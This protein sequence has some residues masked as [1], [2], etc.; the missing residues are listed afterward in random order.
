MVLRW[1]IGY[2]NHVEQS[3]SVFNLTVLIGRSFSCF[4]VYVCVC[5]GK[6]GERRVV[7]WNCR[8]N[9]RFTEKSCMSTRKSCFSNFLK[10]DFILGGKNTEGQTEARVRK[11]D[12]LETKTTQSILPDSESAKQHLWSVNLQCYQYK[13]CMDRWLTQ[14]DPCIE[15]R[16]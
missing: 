10:N 15:L 5:G 3:L 6:G 16:N 12:S 4:L 14:I 1:I 13:H 2:L 8:E 9:W 7:R 11:Y